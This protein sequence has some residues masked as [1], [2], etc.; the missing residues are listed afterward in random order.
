M[1]KVTLYGTRFCGYCIAARRLLD[2]KG[3]VYDD[4]SLDG[5][6]QLRVKVMHMSNRHTVPQI[7]IDDQHIGGYT[8]LR[9]LEQLGKLDELLGDNRAR[10]DHPHKPEQTGGH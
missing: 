2:S 6:S 9:H 3:V 8:D 1:A 10:Y 4:I 7:W 5:D